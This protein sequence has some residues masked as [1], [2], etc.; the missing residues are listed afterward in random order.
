MATTVSAYDVSVD[1]RQTT[2]DYEYGSIE[3]TQNVLALGL[4]T[5]LGDGVD[6][7]LSFSTN[8]VI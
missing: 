6:L 1:Y 8:D 4:G 2:K 7:G 5:S 3:D